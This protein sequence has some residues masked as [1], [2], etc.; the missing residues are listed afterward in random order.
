MDRGTP[1]LLGGLLRRFLDGDFRGRPRPPGD[2]YVVVDLRLVGGMTARRERCT[3]RDPA[4]TSPA[5]RRRLQM[6]ASTEPASACQSPVSESRCRATEIMNIGHLDIGNARRCGVDRVLIGDEVGPVSILVGRAR[7]H[8]EVAG[9]A[10]FVTLLVV[11]DRVPGQKSS[12]AS[13]RAPA[14]PARGGYRRGAGQPRP[15]DPATPAAAG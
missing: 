10:G 13:D 14:R 5:Y 4:A 3:R 8:A 9:R 6:P 11:A 2:I 1:R 7:P 12:S 15:A